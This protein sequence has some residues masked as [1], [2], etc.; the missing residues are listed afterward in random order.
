MAAVRRLAVLLV[1]LQGVLSAS[2]AM[3]QVQP[4]QYGYDP[5]LDRPAVSPYYNLMRQ[6]SGSSLNYHTLVRPQIE[7]QYQAQYQQR[8]IQQLQHQISRPGSQATPG[9]MTG[10]PSYFM[11]LSHFYPG[12]GPGTSPGASAGRQARAPMGRQFAPR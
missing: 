5:F 7:A 9:G 1:A 8:Q 11:N 12:L 4:R 2:T 6:D 10:H 3:A